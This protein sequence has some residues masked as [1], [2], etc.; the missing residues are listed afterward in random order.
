MRPDVGAIREREQKATPGPWESTPNDSVV[1]WHESDEDPEPV[2]INI[3]TLH[4]GDA[5]FI[6]HARSDIP[7][8]LDALEAA[9]ERERKTLALLREIR[10][11]LVWGSDYYRREPGVRIKDAEWSDLGKERV[12]QL[13]K[14]LARGEGEEA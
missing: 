5:E 4:K 6:A 9:E 10:E 14:A 12:E 7:A 1:M 3:G 2:R 13:D 8:L 11:D